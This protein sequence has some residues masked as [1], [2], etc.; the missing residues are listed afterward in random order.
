MDNKPVGKLYKA[1]I[2]SNILDPERK[3]NNFISHVLEY[4]IFVL[5]EIG[6]YKYFKYKILT[7]DGILGWSDSIPLNCRE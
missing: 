1:C 4:Q 6:N 3:C 5:L 2:F 7:S